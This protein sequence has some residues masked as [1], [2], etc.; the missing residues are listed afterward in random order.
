MIILDLLCQISKQNNRYQIL[1]IKFW[2]RQNWLGGWGE[3]EREIMWS[4]MYQRD[5]LNVGWRFVKKLRER[6]REKRLLKIIKCNI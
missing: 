5:G 3:R 6:E 1:N 2:C 4:G